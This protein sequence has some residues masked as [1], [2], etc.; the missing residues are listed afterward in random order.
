MFALVCALFF[1]ARAV[2]IAVMQIAY[3]QVMADVNEYI[4]LALLVVLDI[5]PLILLLF[6]AARPVVTAEKA[7]NSDT[8]LL[9]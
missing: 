2:F 4:M 8:P 3:L 6:L 5:L 9:Q 1:L 7:P